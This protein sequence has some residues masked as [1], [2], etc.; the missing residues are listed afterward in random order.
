MQLLKHFSINVRKPLGLLKQSAPEGF[1]HNTLPILKCISHVV[2]HS[3]L[4]DLSEGSV[5]TCMM[6]P[7]GNLQPH[8]SFHLPEF[9]KPLQ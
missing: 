8:Y 7:V 3:L 9:N 6:P 5:H 2:Q 4:Q 1:K